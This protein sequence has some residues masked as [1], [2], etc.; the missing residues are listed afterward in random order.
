MIGWERKRSGMPEYF[1]TRKLNTGAI[2]H[3]TNNHPI[4]DKHIKKSI[5]MC[6]G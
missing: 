6:G 1:E 4:S 3:L 2:L 5:E